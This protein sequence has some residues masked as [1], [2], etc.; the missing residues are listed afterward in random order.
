[1]A[2]LAVRATAETDLNPVGPMAKV[3]QLVYG[4]LDSGNVTTNLM[5]AG[6]TAAGALQAGDLM[7]DLKAGFLLKVSAR[8]QIIAQFCGVGVGTFA[9][10]GAYEVL[11][12]TYQIPGNVF[13]APAVQSWYA[14]ARVVTQ[15]IAALP[16]GAAVA[17]LIAAVFGVLFICL[18]R[19]PRLAAYMPSP[20]ALSIA[21][22]V[23]ASCAWTLWL[24]AMIPG[25]VARRHPDFGEHHATSLA[26]GLIAGEG[27]MM[28][29]VAL[30]M[31]VGVP[32]V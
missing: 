2:V 29:A 1:M 31:L 21:C 22:L 4:A 18:A 23:P 30:L 28:V 25:L 7:H 12:R 9:V 8:R 19:L 26:S 11:V 6:I 13:T 3:T 32:W 17:A 27:L 14:V 10:V 20:I 5:A 15:G 24:G 16:A